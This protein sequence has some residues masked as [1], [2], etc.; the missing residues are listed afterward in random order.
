M[1][2]GTHQNLVKEVLDELL[3]QRPG[4]E[5]AMEIGPEQLS[6]EVAGKF[7]VA[8]GLA[9]AELHTCPREGR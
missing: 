5:Q 2:F 1:E 8:K 6:H 9:G 7:S 3:L 4:S